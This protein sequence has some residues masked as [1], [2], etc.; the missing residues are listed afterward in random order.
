LSQ[1][2]PVL[3]VGAAT[4]AAQPFGPGLAARGLAPQRLLW[5]D[6]PDTAGRLWAIEQ[7][8]RCHALA[9]VLAWL[10]QDRRVSL[11]ALRRLHLA[12]HTHGQALFVVRPAAL[13]S[14]SSPAPLRLLLG[15][16]GQ[17]GC[18]AD[19]P[20]HLRIL[21]RRGAP[22]LHALD[23]PAQPDA[24][25]TLLAASRQR[26]QLQRGGPLTSTLGRQYALD[27]TA[28]IA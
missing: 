22:L 15:H 3:L 17:P 25:A 1:R 14:A 24:I 20:M 27:R 8:L 2:K 4:G 21:K 5:V 18:E 28:A 26:R 19:A 12:A 10:P 6:H 16:S 9:A 13:A 11:Q 7:G 23:L